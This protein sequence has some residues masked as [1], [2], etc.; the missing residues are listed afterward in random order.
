MLSKYIYFLIYKILGFYNKLCVMLFKLYF[1]PFFYKTHNGDII[2]CKYITY[3]HLILRNDRSR[4]IDENQKHLIV[5]YECDK[6][7]NCYNKTIYNPDQYLITP[8]HTYTNYVFTN[9]S[10]SIGDYNLTLYLRTKQY[11]FYICDNVINCE[12]ILFFLQHILHICMEKQ[13]L[14]NTFYQD[15]LSY[16]LVII[17]HCFKQH[18][19]TNAPSSC[20]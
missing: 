13:Y 4:Y 12:F 16:E 11:N 14:F 19:L 7:Y 10:L 17:D 20:I 1:N 2:E 3:D 6:L 15:N 9:I 18:K 5:T 8:N